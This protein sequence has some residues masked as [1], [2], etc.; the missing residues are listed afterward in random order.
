[1][2]NDNDELARVTAQRDA[3]LAAYEYVIEQLALADHRPSALEMELVRWLGEV[4]GRVRA[5]MGEPWPTG[6]QR[7]TVL[8]AQTR[9]DYSVDYED[10]G[11]ED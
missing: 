10:A 5:E 7:A 6:A 2:H 1:M 3:L 8:P 11:G 9:P 4:V